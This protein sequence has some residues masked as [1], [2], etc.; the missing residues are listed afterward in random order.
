[1]RVNRLI[2]FAVALAVICLGVGLNRR[3]RAKDIILKAGIHLR[4]E[5]MFCPVDDSGRFA[6][7]YF[8]VNSDEVKIEQV[9]VSAGYVRMARSSIVGESEFQ[10]RNRF[11]PFLKGERVGIVE[12]GS[13]KYLY[14]SSEGR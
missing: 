2:L 9:L 14:F 3:P 7:K 10:Y 1:M 6:P 12:L 13:F 11:L 5:G 8:F 4:E